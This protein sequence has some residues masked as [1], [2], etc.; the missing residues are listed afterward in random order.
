MSTNDEN[1]DFTVYGGPLNRLTPIAS[2]LKGKRIIKAN[3]LT[4]ISKVMT[5]GGDCKDDNS[6]PPSIII[7]R[8]GDRITRIIVKCTCGRHAELVCDVEE[9]ETHLIEENTERK[10]ETE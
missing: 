1:D 6:K 8:D 5:I 10:D 9:N 3:S 7:E 4:E 2:K